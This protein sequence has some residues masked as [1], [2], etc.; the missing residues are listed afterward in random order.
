MASE[1]IIPKGIHKPIFPDKDEDEIEIKSFSSDKYLVTNKKFLEF[2]KKNPKYKKSK[3]SKLF[4]D[5]TY[6]E[7]WTGDLSYKKGDD[8][9]PVVNVSWFVARAYCKAQGKRLPTTFEWE[10]FS[11]TSSKE[12]EEGALDWYSKAR[13]EL[14]EVGKSKPNKYGLYDTFGLVWE[15]TDD[16]FSNFMA[17]DSR[18]GP[19]FKDM[20]CAGAAI[21]TKDPK[22]YAAFIRYALRSSITATSTIGS[23]GFRC[24]KEIK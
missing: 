17:G 9:K 1:A 14:V 8:N 5:K 16:F 2:I 10:Y 15:W 21:G 7:T 4:A 6:L 12:F 3:I 24:V 19:D 18:S 11:N 22:K 20:F 23:L 13:E